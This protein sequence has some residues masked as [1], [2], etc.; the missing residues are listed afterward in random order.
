MTETKA[1]IAITY[2]LF[3]S[4]SPKISIFIKSLTN[5]SIKTIQNPVIIRSTLKTS[6]FTLIRV[7]VKASILKILLYP[8]ISITALLFKSISKKAM[9]S[10][11]SMFKKYSRL[12]VDFNK[13]HSKI[14]S[15]KSP[16]ITPSIVFPMSLNFKKSQMKKVFIKFTFPLRRER[17]Q[18]Q[19]D[20]IN[21]RTE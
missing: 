14:I 2:L 9:N 18:I 13:M 7:Y 12:K 6:N 3:L 16:K 11:S 15:Q 1:I 19:A 5:P 20:S 10:I 8:K 4:Y 17:N 21:Y